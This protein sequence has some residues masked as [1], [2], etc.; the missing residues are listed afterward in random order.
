MLQRKG[1]G[2]AC[3]VPLQLARRLGCAQVGERDDQLQPCGREEGA[4]LVSSKGEFSLEQS[5]FFRKAFFL[6]IKL[7][8]KIKAKVSQQTEMVG[9]ANRQLQDAEPP[10]HYRYYYK[11][12][13][14]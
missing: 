1:M 11:Q 9:L 7:F 4:Q 12:N 6:I 8:W 14:C 3:Q 2:G 5:R 13:Y 10:P